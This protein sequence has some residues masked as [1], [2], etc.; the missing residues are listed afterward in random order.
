MAILAIDFGTSNCTAHVADNTGR[1][2]PVPL[3][4]KEFLLP[5][6]VFSAR[7]EV[8]VRQIEKNELSRR[9][10]EAR[11]EQSRLAKQGQ[12]TVEDSVLRANVE[13]ALRRE[14]TQEAEK[15]YWDQTFFTKGEYGQAIIFGTPALRAYLLDPLSGTLVRSPKSF[16]GS[17]IDS[18]YLDH[19]EDVVTDILKHIRKKAERLVGCGIN[20]A[21]IGR[22]V[23]YHGGG[24]RKATNA[25]A[26]E[27]MEHASYRAGL[28]NIQFVIEPLA[29]AL[30]FEKTLQKET[31]VLVV[32]VGG[33]TTD[34]ALIRLGPDRG[35]RR[36]RDGDVLGYAGDRIGGTDFDQVIAWHSLMPLLGKDSSLLSG[37]PVPHAILYDAVSTRNV[38][39]QLRFRQSAH[40]IEKLIS[41]ATRPDLLSRLLFLQRH[42]LQHR[43]V[44]SAELT[45]IKLSNAESCTVPL[46]YLEEDLH[47]HISLKEFELAAQGCLDQIQRIVAEALKCA[48]TRPHTVFVTGGMGFSLVVQRRLRTVLGNTASIVSADMLGTVGKG[49][50]E[51]ARVV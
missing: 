43:L 28:T 36:H 34:C 35:G 16:L 17:S 4:G 48:A 37:Y 2:I 5:S 22:P 33:G 38:P 41:Q 24:D 25:Q 3:E 39:A 19:F 31:L 50:G 23:C 14:A 46:Y 7:L 29:A 32:D 21:I 47:A 51:Y 18:I 11:A 42:Q 6:V 30:E 13:T 44:N 1:V 27:I 20:D 49:L 9:L 15:K 10:K 8:A 26:L 12:K 40:E 45:K